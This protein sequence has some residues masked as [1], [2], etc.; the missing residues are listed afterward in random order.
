VHEAE[1]TEC[2][3]V[4]PAKRALEERKHIGPVWFVANCVTLCLRLVV[5]IEELTLGR[6]VR[7]SVAS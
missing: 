7:Q 3:A 1:D 2:K 4:A 6:K 5:R